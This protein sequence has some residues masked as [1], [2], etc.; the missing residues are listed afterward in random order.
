DITERKQAEQALRE[1]EENYR[2]VF[3]NVRDVLYTISP[4]GLLESINPAFEEL[5]G[6]SVKEWLG[7]PFA[8]LVHPDDLPLAAKAFQTVMSGGKIPIY[9]LRILKKSGEYLVGEFSP[10]ALGH[11]DQITATLGVAR[12]ITDRL[13][14]EKEIRKLNADLE[15]RVL[16]RTAQLENANKELEEINDLFVGR[17]M[18]IIELKEGI[19]KLK[20]EL[21]S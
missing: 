10:S 1:S 18:R 4:E 6:W 7:K 20:N 16:E 19:E 17:E 5:T 21:N 11:G 8:A 2:Q 15:Q 9:E 13:Q 14:K 3:E 12:D